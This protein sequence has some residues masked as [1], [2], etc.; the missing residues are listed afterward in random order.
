VHPLAALTSS[1]VPSV[2][3]PRR[4]TRRA[5]LLA[6]GPSLTARR[7]SRNPG[8]KVPEETR[9]LPDVTIR[10]RET[11]PGFPRGQLPPDFG[12]ASARHGFTID[13]TRGLR[14]KTLTKV[15][16][17]PRRSGARTTRT[18]D[19]AMS[20][21]GFGGLAGFRAPDGE[22]SRTGFGGDGAPGRFRR[23]PRFQDA[24]LRRGDLR[25]HVETEEVPGGAVGARRA[26]VFESGRRSRMPPPISVLVPRRSRSGCGKRRPIAASVATC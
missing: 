5:V 4:S 15:L 10:A 12:H 26:A 16:D 21:T 17:L 25:C 19:P 2:R 8:V 20:R 22:L 9:A 23:R 1:A 13:T 14:G 7:A 18:L 11:R 24:V 6:L 3:W